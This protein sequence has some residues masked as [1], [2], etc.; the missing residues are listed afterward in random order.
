MSTIDPRLDAPAF[1]RN[2]GPIGDLLYQRF[3]GLSG[4]ALEIGSGTGQHVVHFARRLPGLVWWPSDRDEVCLRSIEAWCAA[5]GASN[6]EPPIALDASRE[7][8]AM[9]SPG[10]PPASLQLIVSL[11][12]VHIAPWTVAEGI[13][14]GAGRYLID[15][16]NLVL[17]GPFKRDG[18]HSAESNLRFDSDLRR[19]NPRWG[20]RDI[21]DLEAGA[22]VQGL[23]LDGVTS[24]PAN[25]QVLHFRRAALEVGK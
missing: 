4:H 22:A 21:I 11:N 6:V 25:N 3:A 8:W 19:R 15:S 12:V 16:G 5:A 24:M 1:H 13:L 2:H 20:V 14:R 9:G 18:H 7:D 10:R 17:Y 23:M